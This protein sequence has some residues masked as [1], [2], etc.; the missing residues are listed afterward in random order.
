LYDPIG[1]SPD[2][3]WLICTNPTENRIWRLKGLPEKRIL[4]GHGA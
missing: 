4:S 1:L 2:G 3:R